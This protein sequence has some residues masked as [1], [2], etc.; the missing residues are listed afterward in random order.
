MAVGKRR[1][2]EGMPV[3]ASPF[4]LPDAKLSQQKFERRAPGG[5]LHRRPPRLHKPSGPDTGRSPRLIYCY[6]APLIMLAALSL[7]AASASG[8]Y[9]AE[10]EQP[11]PLSRGSFLG[12]QQTVK[13]PS[14]TIRC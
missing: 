10:A 14:R 7:A 8:T 5:T 3:V 11:V 9:A 12:V 4:N 13:L 6:A 2:L 1:L